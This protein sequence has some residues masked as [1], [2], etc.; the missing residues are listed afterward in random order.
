M[1]CSL[2]RPPV[3]RS[4]VR[5]QNQTKAEPSSYS[6]PFEIMTSPPNSTGFPSP[7]TPKKKACENPNSHS[8][9]AVGGE[10]NRQTPAKG[11]AQGAIAAVELGEGLLDKRKAE[12]SLVDL[13]E[14]QRGRVTTLGL[15]PRVFFGFSGFSSPAIAVCFLKKK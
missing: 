13:S 11:T 7:P 6:K 15:I 8:F 14:E 5:M 2:P 9:Q 10:K 1:G 4:F 3:I 12:L